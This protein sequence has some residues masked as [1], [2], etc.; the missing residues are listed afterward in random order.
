MLPLHKNNYLR[1][2]GSDD[3]FRVEIDP[4]TEPF[5]NYF[6]ESV[7]AAEEIYQIKDGKL[8]V[9][10][11]GGIDSEY[12]L[13]VFLHLGMDVTPVIIKLSPNYNDYDIKYALNFCQSKNLT[14]TIIDID[15]DDF[16]KSGKLF[17]IA[18]ESRSSRYH[19]SATAYASSKL[20]GTVLLGDGE[21]Y[22]RLNEKTNTWNLEIDEHDFAVYNY[23]NNKNISC[24]PHFNRYSPGMMASY[25]LDPRMKELAE[26]VHPGKLGS[27]SSKY[28]V[29]NRH[30]P[31]IL[32]E[33]PKYTGY[34]RIEK[35]EIFK[36]DAFSWFDKKYK[37]I[38]A[39]DYHKF[40]KGFINV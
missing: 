19:R 16:V 32:E 23:L 28:Y 34:E 4:F 18:I 2:Y 29:Y 6:E 38:V 3:S 5:G 37:G 26:H 36:H 17:N 35:S 13:S 31:F 9:M 33:R 10:Y 22:I 21:P 7:L 15:F 30:S 1:M 20:D 39:I 8:Y 12:A 25:M 24:V 40:I 27:N 11:S 14:P